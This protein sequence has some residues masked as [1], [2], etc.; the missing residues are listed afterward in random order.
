M[1][2]PKSVLRSHPLTFPVLKKY[3]QQPKDQSLPII[4]STTRHLC[5]VPKVRTACYSRSLCQLC[6]AKFH[7]EIQLHLRLQVRHT[8]K[9]LMVSRCTSVGNGSAAVLDHGDIQT[10]CML[11]K[12]RCPCNQ[13]WTWHPPVLCW[14]IH[15]S[16]KPKQVQHQQAT[17]TNSLTLR[18]ISSKT[19][20]CLAFTTYHYIS[21]NGNQWA[22][23]FRQ[24]YPTRVDKTYRV[25]TLKRYMLAIILL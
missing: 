19:P 4:S 10:C 11:V 8:E 1:S 24:S 6:N 14:T 16:L 2:A 5:M 21:P 12:S 22:G 23:Q 7:L 3:D 9:Y 15:N 17:V 25:D 13:G 18:M 20:V